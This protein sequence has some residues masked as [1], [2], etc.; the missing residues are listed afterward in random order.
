MARRI[1]QE[2]VVV[3]KAS[4]VVKKATG[5]INRSLKS[6]GTA[7]AASGGTMLS[8]F[9]KVPPQLAAVAV[10]VGSVA[11]SIGKVVKVYANFEAELANV[12]T[13]VD[14]NT[15]SMEKLKGELLAL[16]S[17]LGSTT[18]LTKGLYQ[19]LSAGVEPAKAVQ[20]V[21][22]SAEAAKAGLADVFTA[23]DA[24]TT[25]MNAYGESAEDIGA[26]NDR[27]FTA[28][29]LGKTTYQELASSIGKV[30]TLASNAGVSQEEL[31]SALASTT[32]AGIKTSESVS[33]LKTAFGS[34][35]KPSGQGAKLAEELGLQFDA[36]ALK[37]KGLVKFLDDV[38]TAT[39]GSTAKM[40]TLFGSMEAL[41]ALLVL[42]GK[43]KGDF[44]GAMSA[45]NKSSGTV[46]EAFGKQS[47]TYKSQTEALSASF[48][49]LAIS[50][51]EVVVPAITKLVEKLTVLVDFMVKGVEKAK[52]LGEAVSE[53]VGKVAR[54]GFG[55][56]EHAELELI[57]RE[58]YGASAEESNLGAKRFAPEIRQTDEFKEAAAAYVKTLNDLKKTYNSWNAPQDVKDKALELQKEFEKTVSVMQKGP[59]L[60]LGEDMIKELDKVRN[61]NKVFLTDMDELDKW[62]ESR[63]SK[64]GG[65]ETSETLLN[66]YE[67]RLEDIRDKFDDIG[68]FIKV[69]DLEEALEVK[70][71]LEKAQAL[72]KAYESLAKHMYTIGNFD[73]YLKLDEDADDHAKKVRKL[74]DK[75]KEMLDI[76]SKEQGGEVLIQFKGEGSSVAPLSDKINELSGEMDTFFSGVENKTPTVNIP[77]EDKRG[78]PVTDALNAM[79]SSF[80][81]VFTGIVKGTTS[82]QE[83][84]TGM[85]TSI[86]EDLV[87][88]GASKAL[89]AIIGGVGGLFGGGTP[90]IPALA[91]GGTATAGRAHLVGERGPELFI[92]NKTGTIVPGS[93]GSGGGVTN[94]TI[95][96]TV[97]VQG[98]GGGGDPGNQKR[99]GMNIAQ[100]ISNQTK[101]TLL[102]ET[103][104]G[105]ILNRGGR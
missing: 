41:N 66:E 18:E 5:K 95:Q 43:G 57:D 76:I 14:T 73:A 105:G 83:G 71:K 26:I 89:S 55:K 22:K 99:M 96:N 44:I 39:K 60:E 48:E 91:G 21:A 87:K 93:M 75:Y 70:G 101:M 23:V 13:L 88:L 64:V 61:A 62:F 94:L 102:Q 46:A 12:S 92:P 2:Y 33:S 97:N 90:V 31:F 34:I 16:P 42:T 49:K 20:F 74:T 28:V 58:D 37:S 8:A 11:V 36:T 10:A 79:S 103:R 100:M 104:P 72:A 86:L 1:E 38:S 32:K 3:D 45:M 9:T 24:G 67:N 98:Q 25:I 53:V 56:I 47:K 80:E 82:I 19:A 4:G 40:A 54:V 6:T 51:G 52:D 69:N 65:F 35:V 50:L 85:I 68:D 15:V 29:K 27:M 17:I 84:F 30:A 59:K 7:A 77:F 78:Q 81:N 63:E